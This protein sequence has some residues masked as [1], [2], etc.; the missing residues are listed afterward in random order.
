MGHIQS[1][2]DKTFD[3]LLETALSNAGDLGVAKYLLKEWLDVHDDPCYYDHHGYCQ[4]HFLQDKEE[5]I[6][7]KTKNFLKGIE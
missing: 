7:M 5:C 2:T 4:A 3:S 6:V 1:M